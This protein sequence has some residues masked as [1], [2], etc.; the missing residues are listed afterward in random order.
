MRASGQK[1]AKLGDDIGPAIGVRTVVE[2]GIAE[3]DD[4]WHGT[5]VFQSECRHLSAALAVRQAPGV[6]SLSRCWFRAERAWRVK[7]P[8]SREC[9]RPEAHAARSS[10]CGIHAPRR[11][12]ARS[13]R[14]VERWPK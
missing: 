9:A 5:P 6:S 4:V 12:A 8:G 7:R 10:P 1:L 14:Q 3:Q 13:P 11:R 2:D